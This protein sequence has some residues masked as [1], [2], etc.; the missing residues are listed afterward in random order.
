M[1]Q[2]G[3]FEERRE[4]IIASSKQGEGSYCLASYLFWAVEVS[5]VRLKYELGLLHA[6]IGVSFVALH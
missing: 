4:I 1:I 6:S 3:R 5:R 2:M